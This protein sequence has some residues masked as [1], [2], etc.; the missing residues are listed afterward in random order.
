MK[1]DH[2]L[3]FVTEYIETK[4]VANGEIIFDDPLTSKGAIV[5]ILFL[6]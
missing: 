5:K 6:P 1:K 4:K 3:N 2:C